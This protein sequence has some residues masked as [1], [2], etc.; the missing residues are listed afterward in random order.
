MKNFAG[1]PKWLEIVPGRVAILQLDGIFGSL[2]L[3]V[4]YFDADSSKE[5]MHATSELAKHIRLRSVSLTVMFGD[6]N[7]VETNEDRL[8]KETGEFTGTNNAAES[9]HFQDILLHK[10]F[11]T[12]WS[13]TEHTCEMALSTSR[14]DRCYMNLPASEQQ[15]RNIQCVAL[16]WT[17]G[18][19]THR[20]IHFARTS[21]MR[22][23]SPHP[24]ASS[25][26]DHPDFSVSVEENYRA[27]LFH[28]GDP[29]DP[30]Y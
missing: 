19:S 18:L 15:D 27:L 4:C 7:F 14:I 26:A 25:L 21:A 6:F 3:V 20:P 29:D 2:D 13:Q 28:H 30:L 23:T 24:I 9:R 12:E 17:R 11:L 5:R 22:K 10:C 8:S 16:A 1:T